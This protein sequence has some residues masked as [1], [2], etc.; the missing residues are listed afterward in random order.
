MGAGVSAESRLG[1]GLAASL[2]RCGLAGFIV[3]GV[4]ACGG[5]EERA[6]RI[7][8]SQAGSNTVA[9]VD[10]SSGTVNSRIEVGMLPHGFAL[11]ADRTTLY[12][13]V[14]GSQ[15]VAEI[16]TSTAR[17]RRT[18]LTAPVPDKRED[19]SLIQAHVDQNAFSHT[20]CYGCHRPNGAQP[21]Y[22]GDRP[23]GLLLS[24][25][26]SRLFVSHLRSSTIAVLD[27]ASGRIERTVRLSPAGAATEPVA[28]ARLGAEIWVAL[29][30][31]QPSLLPGA[32][33]RLDAA[34]LEVRGSAAS[35]ADPAALIALAERGSVLV[36]NFETDTVT[37]HDASGRKRVHIAAPGPLGLVD[38]R[39]GRVLAIDY[40]SN[41]VSFLDLAAGTS[42]TVALRHGDLPYANPTHGALASD[43]RSVWI[44]ASGTDGH[45][46]QFDLASRRIVRDVPIDGL[47][48]G[49]AVVPAMR[50]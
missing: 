34:T 45:L 2:P 18:L 46:L 19:G 47:S 8:V 30:P 21:K 44:V 50:R 7:F 37:E 16:D 14:V 29:R 42:E 9:V 10:G 23:F 3:A 13:A 33:L 31:P 48:F 38:L 1:R 5:S 24:P 20:T 32:L 41:A 40:Y 11:S 36:S 25:D 49:V 26:G 17:L 12:V 4:L 22:A 39:A 43:E 28:L 15:A 6:D 35:G 27:L